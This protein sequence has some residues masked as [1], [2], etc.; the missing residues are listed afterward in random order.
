MKKNLLSFIV[1]VAVIF[2]AC[3]QQKK[4]TKSQASLVKKT[5]NAIQSMAMERTPCFG[6]CPA[7]RLEIY[8]DGLVKFK[9]WSDTEYEGEYEKKFD[10]AK[11]AELFTQFEE[12][13]VD[14]CAEAYESLIQ[15]VP[16]INYYFT[17]MDRE[18]K[19]MNAHFGPKYLTLMAEETDKHFKVDATWTKTADKKK[20]Q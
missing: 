13:R 20:E 9:S 6:N 18:Q 19:I 10:A 8:R 7:Y 4:T 3:A 16:G 11:V 17:Y 14:T 1:V 5:A 15:D 2:S 12:H